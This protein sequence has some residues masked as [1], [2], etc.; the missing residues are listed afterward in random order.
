MPVSIPAVS[1]AFQTDEVVVQVHADDKPWSLADLFGEAT[2]TYP[3]LLIL[4]MCIL[5]FL[6]SVLVAASG[7]H[8]KNTRNTAEHAKRR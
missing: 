2:I 8:G 4:G 3:T 7:K 6:T 1:L 5:S